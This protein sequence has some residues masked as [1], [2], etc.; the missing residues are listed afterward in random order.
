[1][2]SSTERIASSFPA[3][4]T[5][6]KSG[7]A[8]VSTIAMI[9]IPS[10]FASLTAIRSFF[11]STTKSSPGRRV[12]FL[13]PARY[14]VSFSRSRSMRSCSFFVYASNSPVSTPDSSSLSR[15]IC[16]LTVW[17]FVSRPPSQRSVTYIAPHRSASAC[18]TG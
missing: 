15:R 4:G 16:F 17:K 9:G 6:I 3:I 8:L 2:I 7:S 13:M 12:M 18:T 10:L 11:E 1:V 5:V 14:F